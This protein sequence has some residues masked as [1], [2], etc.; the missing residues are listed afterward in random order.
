MA[1]WEA[2][3]AQALQQDEPERT[4]LEVI[5]SAQDW[6]TNT[7]HLLQLSEAFW[8]LDVEPKIDEMVR[9]RISA[10]EYERYRADPERPAFLQLLREHEIGG[11]RIEDVLDSITAEPLTGL[12]SIAAGL[13]GRAGKEPAPAR[14]RT[15]RWAERAARDASPEITA[16]GQMMDGRQAFLGEQLAAAPP[17]W[18]LE[19][20]G[21]PPAEP[22]PLRDDWQRRAGLVASYRDAAGI[23][24]PGQAIGPPPAGTAQIREAFRTAVVALALPDDTALLKAMGQGELEAAVDE[25]DRAIAL[26][27][28]DVQAE[29]DTRENDLEQASERAYL[30]QCARDAEAE[31]QAGT[32]AGDAAGELARLAVADAAR[33]EW[34]EAHADLAIR[35]RDAETELRA[36]GL[37]ERI[38]VTDAEMAQAPTPGPETAPM[39]PARW[40]QLKAGQTARVQA[41]REAEAERM[42]RLTPVTDAELA[43]YGTGAQ[44]KAEPEGTAAAAARDQREALAGLREDIGELGAKVDGMVRRNAERAAERAGIVQAAIDEP[45]VRGPQA[46]PSLEPSW[47]PGADQ[48]QY[49]PAPAQDAEPEMEIG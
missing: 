48:G 22:G 47:Q 36:R 38:P 35:A 31:A 26:A 6:A 4:A 9:Q 25:Y 39:D 2:V 23:T 12:R 7:G 41:D 15:S 30:A 13:H 19:A 37:A 18:A 24:D 17:R 32:E 11:R 43:R 21:V 27:P 1:P 46:E 44:A 33:R 42:A 8:H 3:L 40:A 29:I 10:P 28:A 49:E 14:G 20:W 16:A 34:A 5:Q 45:S